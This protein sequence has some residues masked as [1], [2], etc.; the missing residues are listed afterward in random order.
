MKLHRALQSR[1][2]TAGFSLMELLLVT[3]IVVALTMAA[4]PNFGIIVEETKV[5]RAVSQME[6]L[7]LNQR[8]HYLQTGRFAL[9]VDELIGAK[10]LPTGA[11]GSTKGF[12]FKIRHDSGG[13]Y[14]LQAVRDGSSGWTGA[15]ELNQHGHIDGEITNRSGDEVRP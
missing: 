12:E 2:Q 9:T 1:S 6:S 8:L 10:L 14:K 15:L 7:W 11:Q 4:V 13:R 3:A 5:E